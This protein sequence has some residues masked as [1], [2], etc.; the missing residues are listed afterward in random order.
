M[1]VFGLPV[2][3]LEV[4]VYAALYYTRVCMQFSVHL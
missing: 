1:G 2:F 4:V 3:G